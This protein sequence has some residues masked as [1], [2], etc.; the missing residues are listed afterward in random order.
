MNP[1]T[2]IPLALS[3]EEV[4]A[5]YGLQE[6]IFWNRSGGFV[7]RGNTI[8][9]ASGRYDGISV[10]SFGRVHPS[11]PHCVERTIHYVYTM[12]E[13]DAFYAALHGRPNKR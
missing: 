13:F 7:L 12:E 6:R 5:K 8:R 3:F 10:A 11:E 9:D 1:R 4:E 2:E